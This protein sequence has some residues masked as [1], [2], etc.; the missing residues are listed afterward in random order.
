VCYNLLLNKLPA[1]Q[2][3]YWKVH[4]HWFHKK[5]QVILV[6]FRVSDLNTWTICNNYWPSWNPEP[7]NNVKKKVPN[8]WISGLLNPSKE[9]KFGWKVPSHQK[10]HEP[11]YS[12]HGILSHVKFNTITIVCMRRWVGKGC[13]VHMNLPPVKLWKR[14]L[15][16][17]RA[18]P[19]WYWI[20][21]LL[22]YWQ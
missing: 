17:I 16:K 9:N 11:S 12:S 8:N 6:I 15:R 1:H 7:S 3:Q 22:L 14:S 21:R 19:T 18:T 20:T 2:Q 10:T 5:L 13:N 4:H